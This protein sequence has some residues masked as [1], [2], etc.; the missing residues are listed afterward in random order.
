MRT[1]PCH[2]GEA[3]MSRHLSRR[4]FLERSLLAAGAI[5]AAC[6]GLPASAD[7]TKQSTS[8][9]ERLSVAVIGVNGRGKD[10]AKAYAAR[11]DCVLSYI[12]DA[13]TAV[14]QKVAAGFESKPKFVQDLRRVFDDKS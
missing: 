7:E 11:K 10:H 1:C 3:L 12:C 4:V 8:P 2:Q 13:D 14:G 5:G 9:N 6:S